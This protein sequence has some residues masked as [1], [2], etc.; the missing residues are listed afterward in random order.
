MTPG[1]IVAALERLKFHGGFR[2]I[3]MDS[4]VRLSGIRLTPEDLDRVGFKRPSAPNC[5]GRR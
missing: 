3:E 2:T 4:P 1:D 5:H